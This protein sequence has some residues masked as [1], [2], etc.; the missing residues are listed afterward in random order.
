MSYETFKV[1]IINHVAH[2]AINRPT[3]ANSLNQQAWA[4]MKAIFEE[5]DKNPEIRCIILSGEGKHF[6]AGI[7]LSLS[8]I[9]I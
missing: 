4:D 2:V 8:L 1:E 7:D 9:H 5:A 6:C 3:K